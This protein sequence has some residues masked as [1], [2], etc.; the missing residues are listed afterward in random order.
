MPDGQSRASSTASSQTGDRPQDEEFLQNR[1]LAGPDAQVSIQTVLVGPNAVDVPRNAPGD[2]EC[3]RPSSMPGGRRRI[4]AGQISGGQTVRNLHAEIPAAES[5]NWLD[6]FLRNR[7]LDGIP[8]RRD[9]LAGWADQFQTV[10][11]AEN[12]AW[13][14]MK[15]VRRTAEGLADA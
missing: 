5:Q 4:L 8:L 13:V 1:L 11:L 15:A 12:R 6:P 10:S 2:V 7:V 3:G 9:A 14:E